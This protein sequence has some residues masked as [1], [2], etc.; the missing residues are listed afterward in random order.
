MLDYNEA[1]KRPFT[2]VKKLL[3]GLVLSII[4]IINFIASGYQLKCSKSIIKKGKN[5]YMLPEW[6]N[7]GNLFLVGLVSFF[8][9]LIYFIPAL[10]LIF[11]FVG[12]DFLT[13]LSSLTYESLGFMAI[14]IVVISIITLFV[15][16]MALVK[17]SINEKFGDA[18]KFIEI[19]SKSLTWKYTAAWIFTLII[20]L[21]LNL[22][23]SWLVIPV[24]FTGVDKI[25]LGGSFA[26]F[27]SLVTGFTL[28][29]KAYS[30]IK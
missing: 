9:S 7:W 16:P 11:F 15:L 3:I 18:F 23:L 19:F 28:F 1:L 10:L 22:V 24:N 4:P 6:T 17:Y 29:G 20:L 25:N 13:N 26:N 30:E 14:I 12:K 8:I 2:D 5:M 21:V 27:I